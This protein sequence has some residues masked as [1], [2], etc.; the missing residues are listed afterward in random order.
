MKKL[1]ALFAILIVLCF[2]SSCAYE[3]Y[4]DGYADGYSDGYFDAETEMQYQLEEEFL[5]GY[6]WGYE[7]GYW[8]AEKEY[9]DYGWLLEFDAMHYAR[10]QT[11]W[12]PEEAW[13]I[14][15]AYQ[16]NESYY[17][18][19]SSPSEEDYLDAIDTLIYF[20]DYFFSKMYE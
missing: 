7:E 13:M 5:D 14:I 15:E 2:L 11:G 10:E 4:E 17:V 9:S 20:Y 18:D 8:E 12:Q 16:N 19:G 1:T 6:D 3:T